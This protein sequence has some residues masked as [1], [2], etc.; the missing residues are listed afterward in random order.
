MVTHHLNPTLVA[1]YFFFECPRYL[2]LQAMPLGA[3]QVGRLPSGALRPSLAARFLTEEGERWETEVVTE[4]IPAGRLHMAAPGMPNPGK[5][6][7]A[8]AR[9]QTLLGTARPGEYLFQATLVPPRDLL[10]PYG[11]DP[12]LCRFNECIPDLL[13]MLDGGL[14]RVVDV[15]ASELLRG[16]HRVQV[17]LYAIVLDRVLRG[18]GLPLRADVERGGVWLHGQEEPE[19]FELAPGMRVLRD[20]FAGDLPPMLAAD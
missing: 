11:L 5:H 19:W 2:R 6:R 1:R 15:K 16:S 10:A 8:P 18:L 14:V 3:R 7:L 20:F 17:A 4:L 13:A 9:T 12:A